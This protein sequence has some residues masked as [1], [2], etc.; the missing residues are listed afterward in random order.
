MANR[1]HHR[2]R[3]NMIRIEIIRRRSHGCEHKVS[4]TE[5]IHT[6]NYFQGSRIQSLSS[7]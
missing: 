1:R 5:D 2:P 4:N 6:A 7:S 3:T